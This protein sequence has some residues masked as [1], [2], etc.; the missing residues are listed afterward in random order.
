ML[1]ATRELVK[2]VSKP[3]EIYSNQVRLS[4]TSLLYQLKVNNF[5]ISV[6]SNITLHLI[7][8][9]I[10]LC[11]NVLQDEA[12][13]IFSGLIRVDPEA[14]QT[15]AL[16]TNRN[17]LFLKKQKPTHYLGWKSWQMMSVVLTVQQPVV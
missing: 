4:K 7:A 10:F 17:L 8:A 3:K 13:S 12:K 11:K 2:V 1:N 6:P 9:A 14:Q 5:S 15:N 16:Q